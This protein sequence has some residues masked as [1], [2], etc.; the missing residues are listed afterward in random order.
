[1]VG[2]RIV[3]FLGAVITT[4]LAIATIAFMVRESI[5]FFSEPGFQLAEFFTGRQWEPVAGQIALPPLL[6]ATLLSVVLAMGFATPVGIAI[7][8][9]LSEY[10]SDRVRS[11]VKRTMEGLSGIPAIAFAFFAISWLTPGLRNIFGSET[12]DVYNLFAAGIAMGILILPTIVTLC[13]DAFQSVPAYYKD[14]PMGV[15]ASPLQAFFK[16]VFPSA[17]PGII[18]AVITGFSR[19][20]GESVIV[21]LAGGQAS[22]LTLNPFQGA[23][24]MTAYIM[25][26]SQGVSSLE[27]VKYTSIFVLGATLFVLT[28]TLNYLANRIGRNFRRNGGIL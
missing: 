22:R 28:F 24:T 26:I 18:S 9:Y 6:T 2:T 21:T 11:V 13:D 12:V 25:R 4:G 14:G 27:G 3:F 15:G 5:Q 10:A 23:E 16:A 8:I 7:A 20:I 19:S 1:M 17:M